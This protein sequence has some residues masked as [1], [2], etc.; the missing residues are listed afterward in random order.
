MTEQT[1]YFIDA[2]GNQQGPISI[3]Q[4]QTLAANGGVTPYTQV[5]THALG[6][7]WIPASNVEGLFAPAPAAPAPAP[8]PTGPPVASPHAPVITTA[9]PTIR[10]SV[11]KST[12]PAPQP[13]LAPTTPMMQSTPTTKAV[14]GIPAPQSNVQ[15]Q[16]QT[17]NAPNQETQTSAT[18]SQPEET[19]KKA[20]I[21]GILLL[22]IGLGAAGYGGYEFSQN[23][24]NNLNYGLMGGGGF[25]ALIGLIL[26]IKGKKV[27]TSTHATPS[28]LATPGS[29]DQPSPSSNSSL[30]NAPKPAPI[31]A[32]P[33]SD[34]TPRPNP[35][36]GGSSDSAP[37]KPSPF[38]GVST[39][40]KVNLLLANADAAKP[41]NKLNT[42]I[43][44]K[45][46]SDPSE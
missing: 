11:P 18:Q 2:Q 13:S 15:H 35:L 3:P 29:T 10:T 6:E 14:T 38:A 12:A 17:T 28:K 42:S 26:T 44:A 34:S 8:A 21:F 31:G 4:L 33:A 22:L 32:K 37:A 7:Q 30:S 9:S 40:T 45:P 23:G 20:S 41:Q 5:W 36:L 1:W 19:T 46:T 16:A 25:F 43:P 27:P 39:G 24:G